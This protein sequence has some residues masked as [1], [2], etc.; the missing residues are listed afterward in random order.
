[1]RL[2]IAF[3]LITAASAAARFV[4]PW[5]CLEDCGFTAAQIDQQLAQLATPAAFTA[6]AFED[7]DL[8]DGLVVKKSR[9]S[10]VSDRLAALGLG[11]HAMIVSWNLD[12]IRAAMAAPGAFAAS[13]ATLLLASERNVT[14][15]NLDWEPHG[16][17]PPVGPAPTAADGAAFA[18]FV[19]TFAAAMHA[20]QPPIEVS[21]DIAT[22]TPFWNYSLLGATAADY[23][24]DMESYNADLG[25]F[26]K[27]VAFAQAR[28]PADKLVVGLATTHESG[29]DRGKPFNDTE[30]GWR[31]DFLRARGV[32]KIA[33]WDTPLPP[34]WMPFIEKF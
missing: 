14:G 31:F 6:A 8:Q 1:M 17:N 23:L 34:N 4:M 3:S 13:V 32:R 18:A 15:V 26:E 33:I 2:F 20:L 16:S 28:V 9:R 25:F 19:D 10:Q 11:A 30:L 7:W 21:V 5:M 24:M 27:Q 29:P 12:D 22:W